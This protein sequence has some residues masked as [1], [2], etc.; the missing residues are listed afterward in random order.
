MIS[1]QLAWEFVHKQHVVPWHTALT[2]YNSL[3][4]RSLP[5]DT[6]L[7]VTEKRH[8]YVSTC[9]WMQQLGTCGLCCSVCA[10]LYMMIVAEVHPLTCLHL[11]LDSMDHLRWVRAARG[12]QPP[13]RAHLN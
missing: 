10:K 3:W 13:P 9:M 12:K 5:A 8:F 2:V 6:S 1:Q 7:T 11:C 4:E